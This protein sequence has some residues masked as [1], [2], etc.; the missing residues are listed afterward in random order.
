VSERLDK[1][2]GRKSVQEAF[3]GPGNTLGFAFTRVNLN[4]KRD[5]LHSFIATNF[6]DRNQKSFP[7]PNEPIDQGKKNN[8]AHDGASIVHIERRNGHIGWEW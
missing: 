4:Q 2:F 6:P 7:A 1:N 5:A 3:K 8:S